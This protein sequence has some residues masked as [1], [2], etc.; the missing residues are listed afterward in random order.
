MLKSGTNDHS[1][2]NGDDFSTLRFRTIDGIN[3]NLINPTFNTTGSDMIRIAAPNFAPGTTN[4]PIGG[5][6]P[7]EI[8]NVVSSGPLAEAHDPTGLSAMMYVWGQ[9]IDHG[10]DHRLSDGT[11]SIDITTIPPSDPKFQPAALFL[12]LASSRIEPTEIR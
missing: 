2:G 5:L 10:L 1:G 6:N 11:D 7:R 9:F 12:Q 8:G 4:T 3:D